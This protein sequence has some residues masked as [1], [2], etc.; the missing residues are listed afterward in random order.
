MHQI[1]KNDWDSRALLVGGA[2]FIAA[3][4]VFL[5]EHSAIAAV[6]GW[7]FDELFSIWSSNSSEPFSAM[8]M[9]RIVPDTTPPLYDSLL[10]WARSLIQDDRRAVFVLNMSAILISVGAVILSGRKAGS[11]GFAL[12]T[13]IGFLLSGPVLRFAPEARPY[14]IAMALA[15]VTSW[16]SA[17]AIQEPHARPRRASFAVLGIVAA[18]THIYAALLCGSF[19]AALVLLAVFWRRSDLMAS[20]LILGISATLVLSIWL[21]LWLPFHTLEGLY[22][23]K[24]S[25]ETVVSAL[26]EAKQLAVGPHLLIALAVLVSL[27]LF[28]PSTRILTSGFLIAFAVFLSVPLLISLKQPIILGRYWLQGAPAL[29]VLVAF[30]SRTWLLDGLSRRLRLVPTAGAVAAIAFLIVSDA[31]GFVTARAFT[32]S[33]PAWK[34]AARVAPLARDCPAASVHVNGFVPFFAYTTRVPDMVFADVRE[35]TTGLLNPADSLCPVLGW[36][37]EPHPPDFLSR[38][39]DEDLIRLL[40]IGASPSQVEILRHPTGFVILRRRS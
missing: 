28:W 25:Y 10:Y 40:K 9:E 37:E 35:P 22:W 15:F 34:G 31:A 8:F 12:A 4:G 38:A 5:L 11:F 29:I 18:L 39:T 14:A 32:A 7:W 36:A 26:W 19:A 3:L 24:L 20:G 33:K 13:S 27:G 21:A 6:N 1:N 30:L 23:F 2:I 17:S 16:F